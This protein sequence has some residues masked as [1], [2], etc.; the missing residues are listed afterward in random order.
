MFGLF[1]ESLVSNNFK[2]SKSV[3]K[4]S[5]SFPPKGLLQEEKKKKAHPDN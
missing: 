2:L 3:L 5:S 1:V 4:P